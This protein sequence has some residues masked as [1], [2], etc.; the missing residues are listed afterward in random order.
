MVKTYAYGLPRL[1]RKREY[2]R[3][4]EGFWKGKISEGELRTA[5]DDIQSDMIATYQRSVDSFPVGEM[6]FYDSMLDTAI[7]TGLYRPGDL[8]A[9]YDLCRGRQAL[10][11][12]KWFNT[13]YHYLVTDW[14]RVKPDSLSLN[15]NKPAE[16]RDRFSG[17]IPYV[18]GPFTFLKLTK[19]VPP[20]RFHPILLQL[21]HVYRQMIQECEEIHIDEPAFVMELTPG[22]I[23]ALREAYRILSETGCRLYVF[24]YYDSIDFPEELFALPVDG[25]GLDFVHGK[26]NLDHLKNAGFPDDKVL[27]A[28]LVDGRNVWRTPIDRAA[29]RVEE[30][31]GYARQL[32]ISNA[33]PLYHL[34]VTV[35]NEE[36]DPELVK[37]L[38]FAEERLVELS[39]IVQAHHGER[40]GEGHGAPDFGVNPAVRMRVEALTEV[41]FSRDKDY[42]ERKSIQQEKLPLPVYPTTTIGSFPQTSEIRKKRAAFRR[43]DLT[44]EAYTSF[45][46]EKITELIRMQ[47]GMGLDVLVHGEFERSDM[48]EFFAE[49]LEG[50]ATTRS[51]WILSYGT[52]GYRPPIIYG[53]VSR[54]R[55]LTIEEIAFAQ[56]LTDRPVKGMLTGPVTI[57][58]WSFVREDIPVEKVAYQIALCLRDEISDYEQAGIQIVQVD[59]PAFREKAPIKRGDWDAYFRWAI[60]AFR[61]ATGA[62][63][64][65]RI[66]THMCYSEFGNII[67]RIAQLDFDAIFIEA[68]RSRGGVIES[69]EKIDFDRQIG[70]GVW[71]IHSTAVPRLEDMRE[72]MERA[73]RVLPREN[74]WINPDCGLKT[75]G[76]EET[77]A[78]LKNLAL[79]GTVMRGEAEKHPPGADSTSR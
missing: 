75:R 71:D 74:L 63:P 36:L 39:A 23:A 45:I 69:F 58:A 4:V 31:S 21:T 29:E 32:A 11:L 55:P 41:D 46:R 22:E 27:I 13:N 66:H 6:T 8:K 40:T 65:T 3:S 52:R 9:Y 14:S 62:R 37:R 28:G 48:V 33:A 50:I 1:G 24:T 64:E 30:L 20:E 5:L 60:K 16:Y 73:S 53:D 10:E 34:P 25:I 70:L 38:A 61:L 19:G 79:L 26:D 18:I 44:E 43:G 78:S 12:T 77:T 59:E 15:W 57:L 7:M 51:G 35:E 54:P 56:S 42:S 76:W 17:G 47:E 72:I 67:D 49:Q 2:K 68:T